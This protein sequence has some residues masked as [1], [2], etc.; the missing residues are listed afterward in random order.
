M[1]FDF[2]TDIIVRFPFKKL[3]IA[4]EWKVGESYHLDLRVRQVSMDEDGASFVV[5]KVTPITDNPGHKKEK[6]SSGSKI[7]YS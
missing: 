7:T 1:A 2:L 3:P 4:K 6:T 5:E